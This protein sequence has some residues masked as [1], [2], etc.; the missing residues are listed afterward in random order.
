[1]LLWP[2]PTRAARRGRLTRAE[3][4]DALGV[5]QARVSGIGHGEIS[6][7]D[8]VRAYV[9]ALGGSID[10]AARLGDGSWK[11]A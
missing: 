10:V 8:L 11:V 4:A 1:V 9:A 5:P 6:G 7:I 2:W 3:L